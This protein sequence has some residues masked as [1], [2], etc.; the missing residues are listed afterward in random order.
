MENRVFRNFVK[1][2]TRV[3]GKIISNNEETSRISIFDVMISPMKRVLLEL[4]DH[5]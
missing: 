2:Y 3:A 1:A 4:Q 5:A